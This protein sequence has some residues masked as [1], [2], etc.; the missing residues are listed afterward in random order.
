MHW[1]AP[2]NRA[3]IWLAIS[4]RPLLLSRHRLRDDELAHREDTW[5]ARSMPTGI[6]VTA[7]PCAQSMDRNGAGRLL[8]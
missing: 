1:W 8:G 3:D 2:D 6:K 7:P 4:G 5:L